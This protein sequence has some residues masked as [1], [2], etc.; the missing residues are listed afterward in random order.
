L[1]IS[2]QQDSSCQFWDSRSFPLNEQGQIV[3]IE[4]GSGLG[5]LSRLNIYKFILIYTATLDLDVKAGITVL[6]GMN[7]NT[8]ALHVRGEFIS[9]KL[10]IDSLFT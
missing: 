8:F 6:W 5:V 7:N 1:A 9:K 3:S 2:S 4:E 10:L